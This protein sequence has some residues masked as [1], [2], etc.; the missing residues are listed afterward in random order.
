MHRSMRQNDFLSLEIEKTHPNWSK[1]SKILGSTDNDDISW[2]KHH[3]DHRYLQKWT[4]WSHDTWNSFYLHERKQ[5]MI[6]S[7][8]Y[9]SKP[10]LQQKLFKIMQKISIFGLIP[11]DFVRRK[12]F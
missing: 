6:F 2:Q 9:P 8:S 12:N 3:H 7:V 5:M 11:G 10:L 1:T 4:A